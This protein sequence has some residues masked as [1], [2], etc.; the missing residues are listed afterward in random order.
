M[1]SS[2][3]AAFAALILGVFALAFVVARGGESE[4]YTLIFDDAGG[5][6]KGN[7]IKVAGQQMGTVTDID[8]TNDLKAKVQIQVDQLGPLRKGTTAQIRAT[9]LG[10]VANKYI[11]LN[12]APNNAPK[13]NDNAIL[14]EDVTRGITGQDELVNAFDP[15]TRKGLQ[16]F[17][18]GSAQLVAGDGT[19]LRKATQNAPN[20]LSEIKHFAAD[21]NPK[22]ASLRDVIVN[23]AAISS[24]LVDRADTITRLTRNSGIAAEAAAGNGTELADAIARSP[25]SLDEANLAL[26]Q[27]PGTL[28]QVER[29][30]LIAD[31]N[32]DGVPEVLKKTSDTLDSG[33]ATIGALARALNKKGENN[34]AAD[35]LAASVGIG[36]AATSAATN[37]PVGLAAVIPLFA[38]TRA[39]TPDLVAALTG[40]GQIS[41]NYDAAGHYLRL[42]PVLNIFELSGTSGS[43]DLVSRSSFSNRLQGYAT[44]TNRCPGSAAQA[45]SDGSAPFTDSGQIACDVGQV[46]SR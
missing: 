11:A 6:I 9:S 32:K 20:T 19:N 29:L 28:D 34:D 39:Y 30:I 40:L 25:K 26:K 42:S 16:E 35:L 31:R 10:G 23:S 37:I 8:I 21:L 1:T 43:Q 33:E 14:G 45:T 2:R 4:R 24:A 3:I 12:L 22:D 38:K 36:K 17:I 27:L 13:L 41:A 18:K 44:T 46:P 7:L 5:L 15:A